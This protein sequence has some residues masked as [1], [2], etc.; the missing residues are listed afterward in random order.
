[1]CRYNS[2]ETIPAK[3]FFDILKTKDFQLLKPRPRERGL[4]MVFMAIYDDYYTALD[5][6][7]AKE[8]LRLQTVRFTNEY[9]IRILKQSLAFYYYNQTTK[10]M[11]QEFIVALKDGFGITI[12][13]EATFIDEV[14]RVVDIEV[15]ILE[16]ELS[17]ATMAMEDMNKGN[18]SESNNFYDTMAGLSNV[19]V[20][21]TLIN[22]KMTLA[23]FVA[24]E[25]MARITIEN[26]KKK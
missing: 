4:E 21:N 19:L 18:K 9:K 16:N 6:E 5:N 12:N 23:T 24:L 7:Q 25:K 26:S 2:I 15:G 10:E 3:T 11:R 22:E 20:G 14:R 8:F 17:I 13:E 1:M